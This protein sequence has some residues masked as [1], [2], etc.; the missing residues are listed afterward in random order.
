MLAYLFSYFFS[1][2]SN[3][4]IFPWYFCHHFH[5]VSPTNECQRIPYNG[6]KEENLAA[7]NDV[8]MNSGWSRKSLL[9]ESLLMLKHQGEKLN[10]SHC[11][12]TCV[13]EHIFAPISIIHHIPIGLTLYLQCMC[14]QRHM[15]THFWLSLNP[16]LAKFQ[17][18]ETIQKLLAV[19]AA[20]PPSLALRRDIPHAPTTSVITQF[21]SKWACFASTYFFLH[22]FQG[23]WFYWLLSS[24][25]CWC[26]EWGTQQ[27]PLMVVSP[28]G[29]TVLGFE[30]CQAQQIACSPTACLR[31]L[32]RR[33]PKIEPINLQ[34]HCTTFVFT[35]LAGFAAWLAQSYL[36]PRG[37]V[38]KAVCANMHARSGRMKSELISDSCIVKQGS[39]L[40]LAHVLIPRQPAGIP[41]RRGNLKVTCG[42]SQETLS[43]S[44]SAEEFH[45]NNLS[46]MM[47]SATQEVQELY[48]WSIGLII[49]EF[50]RTADQSAGIFGS[51]VLVHYKAGL[52]G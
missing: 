52:A 11:Q 32:V 1:P 44:T 22:I 4:S 33:L 38:Y 12:S 29:C 45:S 31:T 28:A 50:H 51:S 37:Q 24:Q 35:R 30:W 25:G 43:S 2:K 42:G 49:M 36:V 34:S 6:T 27:K 17:I 7:D 47:V 16:H 3:Q 9:I 19:N 48:Y 5:Y 40:Y 8:E 46:R 39:V 26:L 14:A 23:C 13:T 10:H 21:N 41:P 20:A 15:H 18:A